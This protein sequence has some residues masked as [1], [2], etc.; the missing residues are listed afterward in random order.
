MTLTLEILNR[1]ELDGARPDIVLRNRGAVIGREL[2]CEWALPDDTKM[3]SRR[4]CK[5]TCRGD[6][7][8]ISDLSMESGRGNGTYLRGSEEPIAGE[9]LIEHG[10]QFEL[11]PYLMEA[12]LSGPALAR[13]QARREQEQQALG[14]APDVNWGNVPGG[15]GGGVPPIEPPPA[16][17]PSPG[18]G[19]D[20]WNLPGS[21]APRTPVWSSGDAAASTMPTGDE[22]FRDVISKNEVSWEKVSWSVPSGFDPS[23]PVE[24]ASSGFPEPFAPLPGGPET[25]AGFPEPQFPDQQWPEAGVPEPESRQS[26]GSVIPEPLPDPQARPVPGPDPTFPSPTGPAGGAD[27][28]FPEP[29][30]ENFTRRDLPAPAVPQPAPAP[31]PDPT[32]PPAAPTEP[33]APRAQGD[34]RAVYLQ[35]LREAGISESAIELSPEEAAARTG[36]LLRHLIAGLMVLLEARA[37]A[38]DEMGVNAT[39]FRIDGNNPLKFATN[40]EQALQLLINEPRR[41]Y[42]DG[43]NA[44]EDALRDIQSHQVA[45]L[46]AMQGALQSTLQRFSPDAIAARSKDKGIMKKLI[47]GQREAALWQAYQKEFDGVAAGS[48]EAFIDAFSKEFREAYER[49]SQG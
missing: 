16:P 15:A 25:E 31:A 19:G 40:V 28:V 24:D 1:N 36:R 9:V 46:M 47:P 26:G 13:E 43:D 3:L 38:K 33:P 2:T 49:A 22:L 5:I 8:F 10:A 35:I 37:R 12:R 44:V 39:Q 30:E 11:G 32:S 27:P 4:H 7:Y 18:A 34:G 42:M 41:G 23:S 21:E 17:S 6:E 20:M 45:T 14:P 48:A 29:D